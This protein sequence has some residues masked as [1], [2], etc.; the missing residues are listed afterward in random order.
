MECA[1]RVAVVSKAAL[2]TVVEAT[3]VCFTGGKQEE[4]VVRTG[5]DG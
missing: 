5:D 1:E 3:G 2:S 4:C